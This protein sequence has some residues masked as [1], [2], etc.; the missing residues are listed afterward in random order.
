MMCCEGGVMYWGCSVDQAGG[1]KGKCRAEEG[2]SC[3]VKLRDGG[4]S[5]ALEGGSKKVSDHN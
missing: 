3:R 5:I 2:S 4:L 1:H